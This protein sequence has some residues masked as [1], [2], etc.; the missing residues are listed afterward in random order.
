V[1]ELIDRNT[2]AERPTGYESN[3][4]DEDDDVD[5]E[6]EKFERSQE[7]EDGE[8]DR[9]DCNALDTEKTITF[10]RRMKLVSTQ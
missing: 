2:T 8:E 3:E 1:L 4:L 7:G 10:P 6:N 9:E 5:E